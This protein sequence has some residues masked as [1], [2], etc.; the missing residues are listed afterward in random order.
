MTVVVQQ[1]VEFTRGRDGLNLTLV[2]LLPVFPPETVQHHLGQGPSSG[3]FLDLVGIEGDS[4]FG[5]VVVEVL[6][7]FVGIVPY[8]LGPTAG[9]LLYF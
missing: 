9:F 2:A 4:F 8:P 6:L 1:L 5:F 7:S 3:I